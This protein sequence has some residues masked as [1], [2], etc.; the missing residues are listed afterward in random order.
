MTIECGYRLGCG[1]HFAHFTRLLGI[2]SGHD[3]PFFLPRL[4][5]ANVKN[6]YSRA[7]S[8]SVV[9]GL[10]KKGIFTPVQVAALLISSA[11]D[12]DRQ[13]AD[14]TTLAFPCIIIF[15]PATT[16]GKRGHDGHGTAV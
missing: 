1:T 5:Y 10:F 15:R 8:S 6:R 9:N 12:N 7:N 11:S 3:C 2:S 14:D 13:G 4:V 16:T